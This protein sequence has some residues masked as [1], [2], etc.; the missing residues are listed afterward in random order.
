MTFKYLGVSGT[1][2]DDVDGNT[3]TDEGLLR[4]RAGISVHRLI[5]VG[6]EQILLISL[7]PFLNNTSFSY[8]SRCGHLLANEQWTR[9]L[10]KHM[11]DR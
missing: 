3:E 9:C 8:R 7:T 5:K 4:T 6:P 2:L 1:R 11:L 10:W